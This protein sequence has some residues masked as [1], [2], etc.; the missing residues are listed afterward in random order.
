MQER[1]NKSFE[2]NSIVKKLLSYFDI[3]PYSFQAIT[4][5]KIF[6]HRSIKLSGRIFLVDRLNSLFFVHGFKKCHKVRNILSHFC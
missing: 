3:A 5:S 4:A 6:F 1:I 2:L